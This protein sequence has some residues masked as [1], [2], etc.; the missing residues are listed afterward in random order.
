M[1]EQRK[2]RAQRR[3]EARAVAKEIVRSE[4]AKQATTNTKLDKGWYLATLMALA[5]PLIAPK[6]GRGMTAVVLIAM[7]SCLINPIWHLGIVRRARTG[8]TRNWRF[9]GILLI[10]LTSIGLFGAYVWPA[11][12]RH[13]LTEKERA[14]FENALKSQKGE[15]LEIQLACPPNDERVCT[16]AGQFIN[17]V[18]DSGWK[19]QSYVTRITL[20]RP[21]DGVMIYRRGGNRDYLLQH[22]D[23]GGY[24]NINEPHLLAIQKAFQSIQ[25][26]PS[27][28]TNPDI[29]EN[30]MMV[31]FGP[32]RENEAELTD[33][34]RSTEWA[35]G[36]REGPFPGKRRL[37]LCRWLGLLCG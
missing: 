35:T 16:F 24:F 14:S 6:M 11:V 18:G 30:V 22:Y 12:R 37:A 23:A 15:D 31:Y 33:L 5:L 2:T 19:V 29:P 27:G 28:G 34:T 17:L 8:S 7:A 32:E 21:F 26:E 20:S 9:A 10:A 1:P 36:K 13:T 4:K 25:I 3:E